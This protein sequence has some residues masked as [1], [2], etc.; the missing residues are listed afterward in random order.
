[1]ESWLEP[2]LRRRGDAGGRRLGDRARRGAVARADG[3]R[4][5]RA[6]R[7]RPSVARPTGPCGSSAA[8]ATTAATAWSPPAILRDAGHRGR[9]PAALAGRPSSR[10]TRP[11]TS[12]AST[13]RCASSPPAS[14][15]RRCA[16]P[17]SSSTRSSAPASRAR[18]ATRQ[19]R[20]SR[21]STPAAPRSS[22][23]TSPP[24]S[25][26]R[27]ARSRAPPS[28]ADVTVTFHAAKLGHWIAPGKRHTGELRGGA[29]R[30]PRR[31]PPIGRSG[32]LIRTAV[33]ELLPAPRPGLDQVH[34]RRRCWSS[35]GSRGLTGAV[36]MAAMAAAR[37]GAGLR[38]GRRA[39]R[40]RADLRGRS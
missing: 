14:S 26:P 32:G 24:A 25:T 40:A 4:R 1:M 11:R 2:L 30:D 19:P 27:P 22:R 20:R 28:S 6:G 9:S 8:R 5:P 29:D 33:L 15:G 12:S 13:A 34:L 39:G 18:R 23:P 31:A 37:A 16:A 17:G 38:D 35:A 36:C 7:G 21:R 3:D 10:R